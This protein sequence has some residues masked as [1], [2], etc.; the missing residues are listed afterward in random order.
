MRVPL[1]DYTIEQEPEK[2]GDTIVIVPVYNEM[3]H[4]PE[5]IGTILEHW[6]GGILAVDDNSSDESLKALKEFPRLTII[7]NIENCGAGGVLLQ[8]FKFAMERGYVNAITMD[9]DGQHQP[10]SITRFLHELEKC[11][12]CC[13]CDFVWGSRYI[14]GYKPLKE[15]FQPRQDI[16]REITNRINE[17]TGYRLTDVFCGFRAY[18]LESLSKLDITETGYGMFLQMTIQAAKKGIEIRQI[19]IP[20]IYL[21]DTRDFNENFKDVSHR[22]KYYH[23]IIETE[24]ATCNAQ[25]S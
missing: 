10:E 3:P 15:G 9:A 14:D 8:A 17:V 16:N 21:D 23:R 2:I 13:D 22:L 11:H 5:V 1:P 7:H 24:L 18:R 20:L 4:L 12:C 19:P 6:E 25:S